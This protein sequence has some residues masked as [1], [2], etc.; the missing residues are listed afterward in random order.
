MQPLTPLASYTVSPGPVAATRYFASTAIILVTET[1][2][3]AV[4]TDWHV[5]FAPCVHLVLPA[6]AKAVIPRGPFG[7]ET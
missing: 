6:A 5:T 3:G 2:V 1:F 4:N 7:V